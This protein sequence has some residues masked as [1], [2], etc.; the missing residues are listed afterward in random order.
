LIGGEDTTAIGKDVAPAEVR[1]RLGHYPKLA[2][3]TKAPS[4]APN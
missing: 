4:P 2:Q 3:K 1:A